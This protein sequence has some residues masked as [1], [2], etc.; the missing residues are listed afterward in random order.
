MPLSSAVE[1]G[2]LAVGELLQLV[3]GAV[4]VVGAGLA[5]VLELAQVVHD[6]A[7]DVADRDAALLGDVADDLDELACGAPRLSS[8]HAAGG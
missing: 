1:L 4:L 5:G 8:G 6:V 3:L 2:D 7:A